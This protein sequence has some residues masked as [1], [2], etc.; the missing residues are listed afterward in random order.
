MTCFLCSWIMELP[1]SLNI[2]FWEGQFEIVNFYEDFNPFLDC[3]RRIELANVLT[4]FK[5]EDAEREESRK[6]HLY[7]FS[8]WFFSLSYVTFEY[9][10]ESW[11][12]R[13]Y[14]FLNVGIFVSIFFSCP[15]TFCQSN[16]EHYIC[17]RYFSDDSIKFITLHYLPSGIS[18][19]MLPSNSREWRT[20][21]LWRY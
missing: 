2:T 13:Q 9:V 10:K 5:T 19:T 21:V 14:P 20:S 6:A 4:F 1:C 18:V 8:R 7:E 11:D 12:W 16:D 3:F 17:S 15:I